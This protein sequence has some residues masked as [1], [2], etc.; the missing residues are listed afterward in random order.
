MVQHEYNTV[1][2][3]VYIWTADNAELKVIQKAMR[4][5]TLQDS[6]QLVMPSAY[7]REAIEDKKQIGSLWL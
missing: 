3:A 4:L 6:T 1:I 2:R 7:M 5:S